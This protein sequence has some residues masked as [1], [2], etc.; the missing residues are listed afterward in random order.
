MTTPGGT[1]DQS[2]GIRTVAH[3]VFEQCLTT[4]YGICKMSDHLMWYS[5]SEY[6][7]RKVRGHP[8]WYSHNA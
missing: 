4:S 1:P 3:V 6:N 2:R 5:Y 7:I 8:M